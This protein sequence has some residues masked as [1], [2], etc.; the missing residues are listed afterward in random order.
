MLFSY[1]DIM[2]YVD[3]NDV[4]FIRLVFFDI[5]GNMKN[6]SIMDSELSARSKTGS[7][8]TRPK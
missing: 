4:K 6:I 7:H 8:S 1:K 5:F 2:D 3:E